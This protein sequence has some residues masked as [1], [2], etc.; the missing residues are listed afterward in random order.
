VL[1]GKWF[2]YRLQVG[3]ETDPHITESLLSEQG[4]LCQPMAKPG[5]SRLM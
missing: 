3:T 4:A 5:N 1:S 2:L